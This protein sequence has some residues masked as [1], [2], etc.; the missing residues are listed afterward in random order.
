MGELTL[1][2]VTPRGVTIDEHEL[3]EVVVRRREDDG[4]PGSEIAVLRHHGPTL[5][6]SA[7]CVVRYRRGASVSRVRVDKGVTEVL[8]Q[9]VT[10]LVPVAER[11]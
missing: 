7:E 5:V 3:D 10:M 8:D 2:I 1:R 9:V 6:R 4:S 11:L